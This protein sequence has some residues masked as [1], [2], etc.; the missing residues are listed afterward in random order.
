MFQLTVQDIHPGQQAANKEE[1][2][3]QVAAALVSAGNVA[4]GYVAGMLAREQQTSTFLGN[5]IAIPHGTTDTRDQV[6]KTGVQVYQFPQGVTWG[7]GQTAY[8]AIGIAASSDEH[9]GLLRQLTHVLS[10][11]AVAEQLKTA[12]TAEELRAL[13]MG[14]KQS[15]ALKLDN[16]TLSIDVVASDLV[17]LQ[18]LNAARLKE[19][20]AVDANFVARVINDQPLNLGQGIWLNDSAEGNLRSAIAVSRAA[21]PFTVDDAAASVLITVAMA[22]AQPT[23]VLNRLVNLLLDNKAERL[24]NAD[25]ATLLALLTSDDALAGDLLSEEFVVRNEHGLH[26]RPGTV[27]VNTIKQFSSDITVTNLDGSGKPANGRSLMKVVALGVKKGHRL[28]FTAQ[29]DDARQALDAIGEAIA[30][31]LGE[32][33]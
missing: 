14:E 19:A 6:L 10:D 24:L 4:D 2:I 5:G 30:A 29:G 16:D 25:A 28:R 7:E 15:E 27:L 18:A 12:T 32:G 22:D 8:V 31:G 26:A 9:L 11:D 17:T 13:L 33:A 20:G 1:A 21:T 3:R 23:A